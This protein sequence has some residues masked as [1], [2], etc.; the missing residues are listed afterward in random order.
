VVA[1]LLARGQT[2]ATV[3]SLTGG[4]LGAAITAIPGASGAYLG[5]V[6]AYATAMKQ[7]LAGVDG[8]LLAE[9][10]P[11]SEPTAIA[12]A[13]GVRESTGA[14]WAVA[15]TGVAG[16]TSQDGHEPGEVWVGL[17]SPSAPAVAVRHDFTGDRSAV[18][19][20]TVQAALALVARALAAG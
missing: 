6:V 12:L 20:A 3:E 9:H 2:L 16:P 8:A 17:A 10:G 14:D 18:R 15:T 13:E 11:V 1:A 7:R 19:A 4:L 5:G